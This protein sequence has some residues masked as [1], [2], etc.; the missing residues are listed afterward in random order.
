MAKFIKRLRKRLEAVAD[1]AAVTGAVTSLVTRQIGRRHARTRWEYDGRDELAAQVASGQPVIMALWHGRLA[2][3]PLGWDLGWG[4]FCVVTSSARP[5]RLVGM[6]MERFGLSTL[7]MHDRKSN[8]GTSLQVARM[9]RDG[10]NIGFAVDGPMGPAR[11]AKSVPID[12]ARL[13]GAPIW[14]YSNSV[15]QYRTVGS[16]DRLVVPKSGGRGVMMYRRFEA[17]IPKRIDAET[18]EALRLKL[19]ADLNAL[20]LEADRRMGHDGL[21]N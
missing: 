15:E 5:G 21:I 8:T 20:S 7:P 11:I 6:V 18:R 1:S 12:W 13:T 10:V 4:P 16:W 2:M 14:L 17:E 3:S 19:E 9:M